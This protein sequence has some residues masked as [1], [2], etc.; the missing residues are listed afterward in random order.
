MEADAGTETEI[1]SPTARPVE[2]APAEGGADH[3]VVRGA[4][5]H[6]LKEID[7]SIPVKVSG[8]QVPDV[9]EGKS[10][11]PAGVK[12]VSG[13]FGRGDPVAILDAAGHQLGLGLSRYTAAEA[14]AIRGRRTGEIETI[15]GYP[16]RAALIH[17][18][19]MAL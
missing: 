1:E 10:L 19:D 9:L 6:N 11:L 15:L 12:A 17:R 8:G 4:R 14:I 13:E 5:E 16:G 18:D 7:V 3:V 2:G